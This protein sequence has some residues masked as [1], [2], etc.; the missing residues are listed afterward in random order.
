[1]FSPFLPP[2]STP[3]VSPCDAPPHAPDRPAHERR[4]AV[5]ACLLPLLGV[6]AAA[7]ALLLGAGPPGPLGWLVGAAGLVAHARLLRGVAQRAGR[8]R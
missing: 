1:M 3:G 8:R 7:A 5:A 2:T 6:S 4:A